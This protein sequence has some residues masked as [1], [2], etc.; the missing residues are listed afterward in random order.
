MF[1]FLTLFLVQFLWKRVLVWKNRLWFAH[2]FVCWISEIQPTW[3]RKKAL[4]SWVWRSL[5]IVASL[6]KI[7]MCKSTHCQVLDPLTSQGS[8]LVFLEGRSTCLHVTVLCGNCICMVAFLL[9]LFSLLT[10]FNWLIEY[11]LY[12]ANFFF[13]E[14]Y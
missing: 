12:R 9:A 8:F 2:L 1:A 11:L 13:H 14:E 3:A 6:L 4:N 10:S 7:Y 5:N